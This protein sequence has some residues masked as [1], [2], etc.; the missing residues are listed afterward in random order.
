MD[1]SADG[2]VPA[3]DGRSSASKFTGP[4]SH[5]VV[6]RAGHNLPE[7]APADFADAVWKLANA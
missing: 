7:E 3:T 5:R 1:G 4:R 2:V 6:E